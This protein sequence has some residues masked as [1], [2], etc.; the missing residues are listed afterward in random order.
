MSSLRCGDVVRSGA[1]GDVVA[2]WTAKH[3]LATLI[4]SRAARDSTCAERRLRICPQCEAKTPA[5]TCPN[6]GYT[7]IDASLVTGARSREG[8]EFEG[9]YRIERVLGEGG[10]GVVFEATQLSIGRPVAL[11]V[12]HRRLSSNLQVVARF[13]REARTVAA[14]EHPNIIGVHDFGSTDDGEMYLVMDFVEGEELK[15]VLDRECTLDLARLLAIAAQTLDALADAHAAGI[16]HRDL[17]PENIRLTQKDRR[18]EQVRLL[19]FG[20]AKVLG[21]DD[22]H[23]SI[24]VT[25]ATL[26]SPRYMSPEQCKAQPLTGASDIYSLGCILYE[27]LTGRPLFVRGAAT[28]YLVAHVQERPEAPVRDGQRVGG[29]LV[30]FIA[31]C[32]AKAPAARPADALTALRTVRQLQSLPEDELLTVVSGDA[33]DHSTREMPPVPTVQQP[34]PSQLA[35]GA[36]LDATLETR[37]SGPPPAVVGA[38]ILA[39]VAALGVGAWQLVEA[40]D[41]EQGP[42]SGQSQGPMAAGS[43]EPSGEGAP[44]PESSPL[45]PVAAPQRPD[46]QAAAEPDAAAPTQEPD[47]HGPAQEPPPEVVDAQ[48]QVVRAAELRCVVRSKPAGTIWVDGEKKGKTPYE[49]VWLAGSEPPAVRVSRGGY[50]SRKAVLKPDK[51]ELVVRLK[52][53]LEVDEW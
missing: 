39:L 35:T 27:C 18:G 19:D 44:S 25:G 9:R 1:A 13:Q 15:H 38:L 43:I 52:K 4:R 23:P 50:A 53:R 34:P 41:G 6:D 51:R 14:L 24:T 29:P 40:F 37:A 12:L 21:G 47:A 17:K 16:I 5:S 32:V 10:F 26:G 22:S 28:E 36:R 8:E 31:T 20:I 11:K 2:G 46:V 45:V 49:V 42:T 7:T 48:P 30:D 3:P 33:V